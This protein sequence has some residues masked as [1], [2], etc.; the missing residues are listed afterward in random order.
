MN[1]EYIFDGIGF[2]GP[3]ILLLSNVYLLQNQT[4]FMFAYLVFY[5]TNILINGIIKS[6]VKQARPENPKS[7]VNEEY[8]GPDKYGMPSGHAQS[9]VFSTFFL[10]F[11]NS[12]RSVLLSEL[13]ICLLTFYQR[14]KYRTHTI[15]QI[16]VGS[17]LGVF[18]AFFAF[19]ITKKYLSERKFS[20]SKI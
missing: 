16:I 1:I 5:F 12:S 6:I 7:F 17:L 10:Y 19:Y 15:E 14:I 9:S 2:F 20:I 18:I 8:T 11:V 4:I 13:F 3:K